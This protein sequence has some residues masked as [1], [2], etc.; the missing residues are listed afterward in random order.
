[1]SEH[2]PY[3]RIF[4]CSPDDL[5]NER[6]IALDVIKRLPNRPSLRDRV[7]FRI[8]AWDE[9]GADTPMRA[10]LTPQQAINEGLPTPSQCDIV[11]VLFWS[12]MGTPFIH[13]DGK[14]YMSGTHWELL[15]AL[16]STRVET[17]IY[18]RTEEKLFTS[19]DKAGQEQYERVKAF[20]KSDL[21]YKDDR[22]VRGINIYASPDD[23]RQKFETHLED[24]VVRLLR[25]LEGA[26]SRPADDPPP[27]SRMMTVEHELWPVGKSPFL[28]L[29]AFTEADADIYFGRGREIDLLTR[30]VASER[31][32]AVIGASGSGKSSLVGAGLIPRLRANAIS[33]N[34]IGSK[35]WLIVA[36][37]PG[38]APFDALATAL[39]DTVPALASSSPRTY[40]RELEEFA[41]DLREKPNR[42]AKTITQALKG[43]KVWAEVLIV[44][45]QFEELFTLASVEDAAYF[46]AMLMETSHSDKLRIIV[47]MR[48][49]FFHYA[50]AYQ[51]L[52]E[53]LQSGSFPLT[54][55]RRDALRQMIERPAERA[56][57]ELESGLVEQILDDTGD[58]PGGLALM[59]YTLDE[60]YKLGHEHISLEHYYSLGGVKGAIGTRAENTFSALQ[61]DEKAKTEM[62]RRVFH[63]L[64][65]VDDSG[66]ATRR[67][68]PISAVSMN[69]DDAE[70]I[71]AFV[72]ARLLVASDEEV[73]EPLIEVA[74]EALLRKEG[75]KR[76]ADW[77]AEAQEDLILLRQVQNAA[78]NWQEKAR[79][80]FLLW[81]QERL[82]LVYE[83]QNR[84][85]PHWT[86]IELDFIVSEAQTL[87]ERIHSTRAEDERR[88]SDLKR[89]S[90]LILDGYVSPK[91]ML[92]LI[93]S[94]AEGYEQGI[95]VETLFEFADELYDELILIYNNHSLK[96]LSKEMIIEILTGAE[97]DKYLAFFRGVVK[98]NDIN[99]IKSV[100]VPMAHL[101][102]DS[103]TEIISDY[104]QH[105]NKRLRSQSAFTLGLRENINAIPYLREAFGREENQ[106]VRETIA[107][108]LLKLGDET[109]VKYFSQV[110]SVRGYISRLSE[111]EVIQFLQKIGT[112]DAVTLS[113]KLEASELNRPLLKLPSSN[114]DDD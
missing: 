15:D 51:D 80:K 112:E 30:R 90:D 79:P 76:L 25:K 1:M 5:N 61:G 42:L 20:F 68:V 29:R 7:A 77:I 70:L 36:L 95:I 12:R 81:P 57:L 75:W 33:T 105:E 49:D 113:K 34:T 37:K 59:A 100:I 62:L 63:Q 40:A 66:T 55:P 107:K 101:E 28:G 60:L 10:S 52:S 3:L 99:E 21:F 22:I 58:E 110:F 35:D 23:F 32:L 17:L 48:D 87:I 46:A 106:K 2:I 71:E 103:L 74:H 97:I 73:H 108:A 16:N 96:P 93:E 86:T 78:Q 45:D 18:R 84:I 44:I 26:F 98:N 114:D 82:A 4:I 111:E 94:A 89:L 8:V 50:N 39:M 85:N 41:A 6:K 24:I 54:T 53:L 43:E 65:N 104:L 27:T 47:T 14:E 67:R 92:N 9:V 91:T 11:L 109:I 56:R 102:S 83:M 19:D 69:A 13:T 64:V 88:I 72:N 31:F 38:K